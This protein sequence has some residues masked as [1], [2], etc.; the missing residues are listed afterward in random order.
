MST[1]Q[2]TRTVHYNSPVTE[3]ARWDHYVPRGGDIFVCTPPKC[4][5]TWTQA[6]CALLIFGRADHGEKP[7]VISPWFDATHG[8]VSDT[9]AM[10]EAQTHRRFIKTHTPL[11][12]LPFFPDCTYLAVYRDPRD[13]HF[14]M[15]NH[16]TN[17]ASGKNLHRAP[18]DIGAGFRRWAEKPYVEGDEDNFSLV[19]FA[20]H[21]KTFKDFAHL[22]NVHLFHYADMKRDL[23][24]SMT[25]MAAA[26]GIAYGQKD[27]AALAEAAEFENMKKN[28]SQFVPGAGQGR[29]KDEDRFF[30]KGS[31]RQWQGVLSDADLDVYTR[32]MAELFSPEEVAWLEGGDGPRA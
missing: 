32:R 10:L 21:Y 22:P 19:A 13:V 28:A 4:G 31:S 1:E 16:A 26:L 6:I 18:K 20:H 2:P 9:V 29:W 8:P 5:T 15:R 3:A 11:D 17:Q 12:G 27:L 7:G 23:P 24:G 14:S 30:H 25:D